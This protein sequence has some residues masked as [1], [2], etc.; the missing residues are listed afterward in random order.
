LYNLEGNSACFA[1][2]KPSVQI[3]VPPKKQ[4]KK[5]I[6]GKL[7]ELGVLSVQCYVLMLHPNKR[8]RK[9]KLA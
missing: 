7:L 3:P 5:M 1:S 6:R 2:V 8:K 4:K 9:R